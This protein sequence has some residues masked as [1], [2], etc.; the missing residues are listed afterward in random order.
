MT[1]PTAVLRWTAGLF[2][3]RVASMHTGVVHQAL[4]D[5]RIIAATILSA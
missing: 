3:L 2:H 1:L 5:A 4:S